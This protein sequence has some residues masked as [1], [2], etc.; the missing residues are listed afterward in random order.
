MSGEEFRVKTAVVSGISRTSKY[1]DLLRNKL[2]VSKP[3]AKGELEG[4]CV[5]LAKNKVVSVRLHAK[6]LGIPIITR[7]A[8]VKC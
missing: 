5:T 2:T 6:K 4:V 1:E 7:R 3:N 8:D